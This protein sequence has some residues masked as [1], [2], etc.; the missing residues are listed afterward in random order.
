MAIWKLWKLH[1]QSTPIRISPVQHWML[2]TMWRKESLYIAGESIK[3]YGHV[4]KQLFFFLN[5]MK[6]PL[7][8]NPVILLLGIH[9]KTL[10]TYVHMDAHGRFLHNCQNH[11][12][13]ISSIQSAKRYRK[14]SVANKNQNFPWSQRLILFIFKLPRWLH[15]TLFCSFVHF[16]CS[17]TKTATTSVCNSSNCT[18]AFVQDS[19]H[20]SICR[21]PLSA[22]HFTMQVTNRPAKG[23]RF[24]KINSFIV[25]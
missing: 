8:M 1:G 25:S 18:C 7:I 23:L 9:P 2:A 21:R 5:Q 16:F 10:K 20:I 4:G 24:N 13:L 6:Q 3:W 14:L 17:F 19:N 15:L 11:P 12:L 22:P